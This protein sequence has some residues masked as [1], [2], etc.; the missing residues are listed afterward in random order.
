MGF[1]GVFF[2][3]IDFEEKEERKESRTLQMWWEGG[4]AADNSSTIFTGV[5]DNHYSNPKAS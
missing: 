4:E 5:F 3:R 2:A 1:D